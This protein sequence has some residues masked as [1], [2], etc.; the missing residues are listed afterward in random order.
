[1]SQ[2]AFPI[3]HTHPYEAATQDGALS[4]PMVG[5]P[6]ALLRDKRPTP[7]ER[8]LYRVFLVAAR[9]GSLPP[10]LEWRRRLL[11]CAETQS[12]VSP[13]TTKR[14]VFLLRLTRWIHQ[15][16]QRH[17]PITG[18][19]L[20]PAYVVHDTPASFAT[21]CAADPGY[22]DLL[23]DALC[24]T[25]PSTQAVAAGVLAEL[26]A[27]PTLPVVLRPLIAHMRQTA[28]GGT[29]DDESDPPAPPS[30]SVPPGSDETPSRLQ[31]RGT[32]SSHDGA[33]IRG[34]C[35]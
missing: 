3:H 20:P 23:R 19:P 11:A 8:N 25:H 9:E 14:C 18:Q 22:A 15:E 28:P 10:D 5:V 35:P 12:L 30:L 7:M 21:V 1:M 4:L 2:Q 26:A 31:D 6:L 34:A 32:A 27:D 24:D 13:S 33:R 29:R 16:P 17:D